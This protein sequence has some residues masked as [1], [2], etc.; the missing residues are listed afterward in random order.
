MDAQIRRKRVHNFEL[1][2]FGTHILE[3]GNM[4][5]EYQKFLTDIAGYDFGIG[6][7]YITANM[8]FG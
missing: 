6:D 5:A 3:R 7:L 8:N 4:Y 2:L 1:D